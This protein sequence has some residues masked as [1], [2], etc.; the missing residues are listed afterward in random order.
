VLRTEGELATAQAERNRR[1]LC[2]PTDSR[3]AWDNL[4]ALEALGRVRPD[5][6]VADIGCRNG[7]LLTWLHQAGYRRLWGC[8]LKTP[9]PA[10][11][12]AVKRGYPLTLLHGS[13]MFARNRTR[14]RRSRAENTTFPSAEFAAVTSMSVIEHSVDTE[15]FFREVARLLRPGGILFLSTDYWT[16]PMVNRLGDAVF[17][18]DDV[19]RLIAEAGSA[20][21]RPICDLDLEVGTPLIAELGLRYTF[22]TLAFERSAEPAAGT[23]PSP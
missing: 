12:R 2:P 3:K 5:E 7:I 13:A 16:T 22:L 17:G 9:M 4:L 19:R 18:P 15:A 6:S 21:L 11:A 23:A 10:L 14:M 8:D 20:S 1:G